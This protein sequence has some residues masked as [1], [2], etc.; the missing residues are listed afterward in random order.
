GRL[1]RECEPTRCEVVQVAGAGPI[2]RAPGLNL[3]RV[4][5]AR[6]VSKVPFLQTSPYGRN[7]EDILSFV[8]PSK[9]PPFLLSGDVAGVASVPLMQSIFRTYAWILPLR[10]SGVHP[11]S[12]DE[13]SSRIG[14][15]R[16]TL[17]SKSFYFDL[18]DPLG[19]LAP[20]VSA[21]HVTSRRLLLVGGQ[22][23]ALL[24]AFV[25]LVAAG[26]RTEAA[27]TRGRMARFGARRW[28]LVSLAVVEAAVLGAVATLAGWAIGAGVGAIVAGEAGSPV[29]GALANSIVSPT[30][31]WLAL[32]LAAAAALV[33]LLALHAPVVHVARLA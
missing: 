13:L 22:A 32:G 23:A 6:L 29:G 21:N 15:A 25:V 33:L 30:G 12:L 16:S 1:P 9:R 3:V 20:A 26:G 11:W 19:S 2:P 28:Q 14:R 27:A 24:L 4:G 8:P 18:S 5:Y 17:T 10:P 31:I 7:A